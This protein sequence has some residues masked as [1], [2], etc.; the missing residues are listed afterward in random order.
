MKDQDFCSV[1]EEL[2]PIAE[3]LFEFCTELKQ[4]VNGKKKLD[5]AQRRKLE[6]LTNK[7][8]EI[9]SRIVQ[10]DNVR[11]Y[12]ELSENDIRILEFGSG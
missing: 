7:V 5:F 2:F 4:N 11:G 3:D 1:A 6:I 12:C 9:A 10:I 8:K